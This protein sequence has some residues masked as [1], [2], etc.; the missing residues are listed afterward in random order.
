MIRTPSIL[1]W[2]GLIIAAS[3]AL[4]RTSDRVQEL[5]TQLHTLDASIDSEQESIHV[6]K[7]EWGDRLGEYFTDL[8]FAPM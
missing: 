3:I 4:Y 5:N 6:L 2:F 8:D 1:F 7:A